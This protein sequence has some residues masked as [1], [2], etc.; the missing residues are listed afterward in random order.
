M[1][2]SLFSSAS[3][4]ARQVCD[5]VEK[6]L[7]HQRDLLKPEAVTAVSD[8]IN[9]LRAASRTAEA[10][11]IG[12]RMKELEAVANKWLHPYPNPVAREWVEMLLV[13][14][15]VA[16]GIR[17]F[18]LQP[19]SI[20]TGSMQPTLFGITEE[21]LRGTDTPIPN[22]V[23]R[24]FDFWLN[25][26]SYFHEVADQAGP[27]TWSKPT[28]F[29]LFNL[30]QTYR[31]GSG[32]TK[33]IFFPPDELFE[34]RARMSQGQEVQAGEEFIKTKV[35]TGDHLFVDRLT[36]NFRKPKRGEIIVFET[37]GIPGLAQDQYYIKRLVGLSNEK[38]SIGDD[39][40]LVVN[41]Q[42]LDRDTPY[43][44]NVYGFP[45]GRPP[46][47]SVYSG[48][49][50]EPRTVSAPDT[51]ASFPA[52]FADRNAVNTVRPNHLMVMGDNTMNSLDS[53]MWG[54]FSTTNVIGRSFMV[55]WPFGGTTLN[56]RQRPMRFGWGHR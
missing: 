26:V 36:Y 16:V 38:L 32:D 34:R 39:R 35:I 10:D 4:H 43:F 28:K 11:I 2:R 31:I 3:R 29:L 23:V 12:K 53:R 22:P 1:L 33:Y 30:F 41:G 52:R 49:I 40:H 55:Y 54:D 13:A 27:V 19:F 20:P 25:G 42:R 45:P 46:A 44:E 21:N 18:F 8:G 15:A 14:I 17:T 6:V 37:A 7:N 9:A 24:F 51:G 56:G 47:E 50:Q 48:H 5:N